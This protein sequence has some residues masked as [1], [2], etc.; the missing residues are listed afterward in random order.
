MAS[1]KRG[2]LREFP[3]PFLRAN[4]PLSPG[5]QGLFCNKVNNRC[6]FKVSRYFPGSSPT[7]FLKDTLHLQRYESS[8][9]LLVPCCLLFFVLVNFQVLSV[10]YYI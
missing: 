8:I 9:G 5:A 6:Y 2:P 7:F 1:V 3:Q 10:S 4:S